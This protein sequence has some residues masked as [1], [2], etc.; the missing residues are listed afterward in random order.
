MIAAIGQQKVLRRRSAAHPL[1]RQPGSPPAGASARRGRER[2]FHRPAGRAQMRLRARPALRFPPLA[3]LAGIPRLHLALGAAALA[4][5]LLPLAFRP[6][7]PAALSLPSGGEN[8]LLAYLAPADG[9]EPEPQ[10]G[11]PLT[12]RTNSY[13]VQVGDTLSGIAQRS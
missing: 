1:P 7:S 10:G 5:A 8:V 13:T 3:W 12:L 11:P 6:A 4:A 2:R 9:R